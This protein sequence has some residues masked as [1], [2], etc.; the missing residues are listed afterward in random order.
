MATLHLRE[1]KDLPLFDRPHAWQF[2]DAI[3][4]EIMGNAG[5]LQ[6]IPIRVIDEFFDG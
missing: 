3:A 4:G 2:A 5:R 6:T 1:I